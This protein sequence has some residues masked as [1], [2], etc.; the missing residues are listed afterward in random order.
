MATRSERGRSVFPAAYRSLVARRHA[1]HL[2]L[3]ALV[4]RMPFA[5]LSLALLLLVEQKT[6]S[7]A[8]AGAVLAAFSISVG[9]AAP[10]QG[11]LVDRMGQTRVLVPAA[12]AHM[13]ALVAL[14]VAALERPAPATLVA[15]AA[16]V[17]ASLP[18]L[19]ACMRALWPTLVGDG[20]RLQAA[21]ALESVV[22]EV[23]FIVGPLLTGALVLLA[24]PAAATL[25]S[26]ALALA[27]TLCFAVCPLSREWRGGPRSTGVAGALAAPG[28]RVLV[29][30]QAAAA[31]GV[32][33]L[34]VA[35]PAFAG[36]H[37][38]PGAA[39]ALLAALGVGSLAGGLWFGA[40]E[41]S[42]SPVRRYVVLLGLFATGLLP[43]A[44]AG[45]IALM[46]ALV[47]LAGVALAPMTAASYF[48]IDR[49]APPGTAAEAYTW[50]IVGS[51]AGAAIGAAIAG[52]AVERA[53]V[54]A[55]FLVGAAGAA[56]GMMLAL[57]GRGALGPANVA[58]GA[59]AG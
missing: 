5:I 14:V 45:S 31:I 20:G 27:G 23:I 33:T 21:F 59:G 15:L 37:G 55:A 26:G 8:T 24:S 10:L 58:P 17:G 51:A 18:P 4:G 30:C 12:V 9:V 39:G 28:M 32:G 2:V 3:A 54:E 49:L 19:S 43:L 22:I 35:V 48:L 25:V 1:R 41:W 57:A 47:T 29:A 46:A 11:R 42:G 36:L 38:D 52:V 6:G 56:V 53:G 44:L 50:P 34:G 13:L 40:R 16:L 7:Y